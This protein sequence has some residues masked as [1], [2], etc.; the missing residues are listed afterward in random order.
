MIINFLDKIS[1]NIYDNINSKK[2]RKIPLQLHDKARRLMDQL[3]ASISIDDMN[4]PPSNRLEQLS[5]KLSGFWSVRINMQWRIIFKWNDLK[6]N[7]YD[8]YIDDYHS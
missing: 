8:V 3:D 4:V 1:Q 5:G 7:A 6:E 2:T